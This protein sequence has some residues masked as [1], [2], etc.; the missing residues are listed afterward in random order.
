MGVIMNISL[1][2]GSALNAVL[3]ERRLALLHALIEIDPWETDFASRIWHR[4]GEVTASA[5]PEVQNI[6]K[7]WSDISALQ[8]AWSEAMRWP[9]SL[10]LLYRAACGNPDLVTEANRLRVLTL[11]RWS[12]RNKY[13][14]EL[15]D[16]SLVALVFSLDP[17]EVRV[18]DLGNI[19]KLKGS[20][21]LRYRVAHRCQ[22][23]DT[24]KQILHVAST[25]PCATDYQRRIELGRAVA[26]ATTAGRNWRHLNDLDFALL[27]PSAQ[28]LVLSSSTIWPLVLTRA[29]YED[30]LFAQRAKDLLHEQARI[31]NVLGE[32]MAS[33]RL[34]RL[35]QVDAL[36]KQ[37][38]KSQLADAMC[39]TLRGAEWALETV[40][41]RDSHNSSHKRWEPMSRASRN[42]L[43]H[44]SP[45]PLPVWWTMTTGEIVESILN[46]KLDPGHRGC[47]FPAQ[48]LELIQKSMSLE[49]QGRL[50]S[51]GFGGLLSK[52]MEVW[53]TW[54]LE[55]LPKAIEGMYQ[56]GRTILAE[57]LK[58]L[59]DA[60]PW[61][62]IVAKQTPDVAQ[63]YVDLAAQAIEE[64]AR[65][66]YRWSGPK[67]WGEWI[68]PVIGYQNWGIVEPYALK[69]MSLFTMAMDMFRARKKAKAPVTFARIIARSLA[70]DKTLPKV[71]TGKLRLWIS[72]D[73]HASIAIAK[74]AP[75]HLVLQ[76]LRSHSTP[77][78]FLDTVMSHGQRHMYVPAWEQR[79]LRA[80]DAEDLATQAL[81]APD[82]V[83]HFPWRPEWLTF[84]NVDKNGSLVLVAIR[85]AS[86][87]KLVEKTIG[88]Q[89]FIA[90]LGVAA[91][92][93]DTSQLVGRLRG[94]EVAFLELLA[95]IGTEH[96]R[97]LM[98][99]CMM[100][101]RGGQPGCK[102]DQAYSKHTIPKKNGGER[103]ISA[104]H[105]ALKQVQRAV[106]EKLLNPLGAHSCAYGFVSGK[107]IVD[108]AR[109]H[110]GQPV[111]VNADIQSCFPSVK[112]PL[113]LG[114][115]R[116]H[117]GERF[118]TGSISMLTDICTTQGAL[119]TGA[120]TSPALLNLV[121]WRTD[122][123]LHQRAEEF[124][125]RYTRY[126][127]DL[128]FSGG[129]HVVG[130]L[131]LARYTLGQ[132]G[133][134]LD[135]QKT[136]IFRRGRRQMVTGLVVN[137]Q[138]S[139][140]RVIRRLLRAAVHRHT[141]EG[142]SS[143][144]GSPQSETALKGRISFVSM[145]DPHH[146]LPLAFKLESAHKHAKENA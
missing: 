41:Y 97:A 138:V 99:V 122:E 5:W 143:W 118:T 86:R 2:P 81:L 39:Q 101:A 64:N 103:L 135:P 16:K 3:Q 95:V 44:W 40:T 92:R 73:P 53:K 107:S 21:R 8:Q 131:R 43:W 72:Q 108:N 23:G 82:G 28:S 13:V 65:V 49:A 63:A 52:S 123:V 140:P 15:Q 137:D 144:K 66:D 132:I 26:A 109:M 19:T 70:L 93:L 35:G 29:L 121:L 18:P 71:M 128:T 45:A 134:H 88:Q 67:S 96:T 133:L 116:R 84:K 33:I 38:P 7:G 139:V 90:A 60:R 56:H 51:A 17:Q 145:V 126:A 125:L 61:L 22:V 50:V 31:R 37:V 79:L 112:W 62:N 111:V 91:R 127:D 25:Q 58:Q 10:G 85:S 54:P 59:S 94:R 110:V 55:E 105:P 119:P 136:N 100:S 69:Q 98:Q 113:V 48:D 83:K 9:I 117:L 14:V 78:E 80:T 34:R 36:I 42:W 68:V 141:Q 74:C 89:A 75:D 114:V 146:G 124:G 6:F 57:R 76:L 104:P 1:T 24:L 27:S 47:N 142:Q 4:V 106:L 115:L 77:L 120:P 130:M 30:G 46:G 12:T 32:I 11:K 129:S 20:I 102:L 87:L